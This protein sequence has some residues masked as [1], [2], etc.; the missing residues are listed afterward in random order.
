[1]QAVFKVSGTLC[2]FDNIKNETIEEKVQ[3][4]VF[5]PTWIRSP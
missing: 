1:M 2:V 4:S 5:R 3:V